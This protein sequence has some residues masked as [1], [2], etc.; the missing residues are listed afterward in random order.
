LDA[1]NIDG[2]LPKRAFGDGSFQMAEHG[3]SFRSKRSRRRLG[4][5]DFVTVQVTRADLDR[6]EVELGLAP[7]PGR[8]AK[9]PKRQAAGG[10]RRR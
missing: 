8:G 7:A 1:W 10:R 2:F 9:R 3:F 4:L 5:G 6:R